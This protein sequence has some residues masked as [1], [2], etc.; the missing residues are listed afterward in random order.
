M[1]IDKDQIFAV[2]KANTLLI[3]SDVGAN[4]VTIDGSLTDL[5]ANSIDRVEIVMNSL[6]ELH[7]KIPVPE[8]HGLKSLRAVVDLFYRYAAAQ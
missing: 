4:D 1:H 2:L 6:Q 5:G 7:L 3:L 8:L